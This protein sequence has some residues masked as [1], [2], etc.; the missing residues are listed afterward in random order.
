MGLHRSNN[1]PRRVEH[2]R[3]SVDDR[4]RQHLHVFCS[5]RARG[6]T[7][8]RTNQ[9]RSNRALDER[10]DRGLAAFAGQR[11]SLSLPGL[12][13]VVNR[14]Q[15]LELFG[16]CPSSA[17][18]CSRFWSDDSVCG[19]GSIGPLHSSPL[20]SSS[21]LGI[22]MTGTLS[23]NGISLETTRSSTSAKGLTLPPF[24][25]RR[26]ATGKSLGCVYGIAVIATA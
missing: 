17:E 5:G 18:S 7:D 8:P 26:I 12:D 11:F 20:S 21:N 14:G 1:S 23:S 10:G 13:V 9:L 4:Q 19:C 3:A 15:I 2:V 25:P 6:G 22:K 16:S 24:L